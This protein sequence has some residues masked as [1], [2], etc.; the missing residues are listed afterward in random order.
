MKLGILTFHSQLNYGGVLQCWALKTALE[1]L[2]HEVV[3]VDRWLDRRNSLLL[4]EFQNR[5]LKG[6]L[7]LGVR[8]LLGCGDFGLLIRAIRTIRFVRGL[9]LTKEHFYEWSEIKQSNNK[10]IEQVDLLVVG[11]DQVWHCGDWGDPRVY[12]LEGAPAVKAISYAASFGLKSLPDAFPCGTPREM[13]NAVQ[14]YREGLS[15]FAAISCREKEGVE[16]CKGLGF[17]ATHVADPTLLLSPDTWKAFVGCNRAGGLRP[18]RRKLVCYFMSVQVEANLPLL[19]KFAIAMDCTVEV[20]VNRPVLQPLPKSLKAVASN[21]RSSRVRICRGYGP[22][23][24]V[25][26]FSSAT[27]VV[28]DSFHAVMFASIFRCNA[29]FVRPT[30]KMREGMFARIVEFAALG[31]S[32]SF[33]VD[34]VAMALASFEKGETISY[35]CSAIEERRRESLAWLKSAVEVPYR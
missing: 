14:C 17:A 20:L 12:L 2:G 31:I 15:K 35:N 9:G 34:R 32:G 3:V 10:A 30:C 13:R 5:G 7:K 1:E 16:I 28:T 29:R 4:G 8:G 18:N 33:F 27:W 11:S 24:F 26:A 6:W 21:F 19:E 25:K 22:R 23:E